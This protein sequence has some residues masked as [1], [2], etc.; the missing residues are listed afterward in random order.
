M[1][2]TSSPKVPRERNDGG[3]SRTRDKSYVPS[4]GLHRSTMAH[5]SLFAFAVLCMLSCASPPPTNSP[6]DNLKIAVPRA[7]NRAVSFTNKEAAY[8]YTQTHL[9]DHPEHTWFEGLNV[10]KNRVFG[11]YRL[12]ADGQEV[13]N[14]QAEVTVYP[15][16][17]VREHNELTEELWMLDK[18]N[19]IEV[20]LAGADKTIGIALKG[21]EVNLKSQT[22]TVA[23]FTPMEGDFVIAVCTK[24]LHP[25]TAQENLLTADAKAGGFYVGVGKTETEAEAL[26]RDVQQNS[27]SL[28]SARVKR[29]EHFLDER[30]PVESNLDSLDKALAWLYLTTDQLVTHQQGDGIYAGLPWFNEYWGRDEFISFPGAIL[31]SGQ[32]E[33]GKKILKS[34]ADYQD[35]DKT[36]TFFGRVPNIV[37]PSNIDYHT[38]DGTPRFIME[39]QNYVRYFGDTSLIRELYP[40]VVNSIEGALKNWVDTKGYL[41][42]EDNETWMDARD[43]N[44]V[45]YSPRGTRANDI[46]ALWYNQLRAG[47]YFATYMKDTGNRDR[48]DALADKLKTNFQHDFY[49]TE[50]D[51]LA[52]RLTKENKPDFTLRPNQ[53]FALDMMDDPELK[54]KA[55]RKVWEELIYPWGVATLDRHHPFFHPFHLTAEYHKDAAYH[56]G[57]IWPWLNG[58]AM[59]RMIEFEQ[60]ETAYALFKNMNRQALT[61][62]VVGG[63][64]ENLDAYPHEGHKLPNLTGTYLQAWSNAE[65]LRIWNQWFLGFRPDLTNNALTIAPRIPAEITELEYRVLVG[66]GNISGTYS[67]SKSVTWSYR[68]DDLQFGVDIDIYPYELTRLN[69]KPGFTVE[70]TESGESL[71]ISLHDRDKLIREIKP[72]RSMERIKAKTLSDEIFRGIKFAEPLDLKSHPVM[73]SIR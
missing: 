66:E 25:I 29:M 18:V 37:N 45:S 49:E 5:P 1:V 24:T 54:A 16:K 73:R 8:Y 64:S 71:T 19:I 14:E 27:V 58:I 12:Y 9:A 62:G 44:L 22:N 15:Y 21:K 40:T 48:W 67:K 20:S 13:D 56:N 42:H 47:A 55:T 60:V 2:F 35:K 69:I 39:L 43:A 53:L 31:V 3:H 32:S 4:N 23:F 59:Q 63:L 50:H 57:A 70:I 11:G 26:L 46:Q 61:R 41:L 30:V 52:D 6:L 72:K 65:Q 36:S 28:K 68:F 33:T 7:A 34:F 38:T 17:L 51:Y 10:A